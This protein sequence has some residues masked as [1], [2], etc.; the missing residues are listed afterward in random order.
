[1]ELSKI[2][3][4]MQVVALNL[5]KLPNT[6]L[7]LE[8]LC[9]IL[10]HFLGHWAKIREELFYYI[11]TSY[12]RYI[13]KHYNTYEYEW[14]TVKQVIH[15]HRREQSISF[16]RREEMFD[17][18]GHIYKVRS[19]FIEANWIHLYINIAITSILSA[20]YAWVFIWSRTADISWKWQE[21]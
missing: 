14:I 2:D 18:R 15:W 21:N 16:L 7:K 6:L 5:C 4:K 8:Y 19:S 11:R 3:N 17:Q 9:N 1:M 20:Y 13:Y 10:N 12:G